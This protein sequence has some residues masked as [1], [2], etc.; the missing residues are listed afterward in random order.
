MRKTAMKRPV[1]IVVILK[2]SYSGTL[3]PA[4]PKEHHAQDPEDCCHPQARQ[5]LVMRFMYGGQ[6]CDVCHAQKMSLLTIVRQK[7]VLNHVNNHL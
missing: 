1:H 5:G 6:A 4:R 2:F 7:I 3:R